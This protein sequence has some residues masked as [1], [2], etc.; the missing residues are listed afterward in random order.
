MKRTSIVLTLA[1]AAVLFT[2]AAAAQ[3]VETIPFRAILSSNNEVPAISGLNATGAATILLHVVRDATGKVVSGSVDFSNVSY[4][5]PAAVTIVASHIHKGTAADNGPVVIPAFSGSLAG[6]TVGVMDQTQAQMSATNLDSVNGILADPSQYYFNVHTTDNPGGAMRGQLQRA[7]AVVL[8]GQ[9]SPANEV[10]TLNPEGTGPAG[11]GLV[12]A[13]R[14]LDANGNTTSGYVVFDVNYTGF[15]SDTVFVGLHIHTGAAG[16]NGPVT[17]NSGLSGQVPGQVA[18]TLHYE[19]EMDISKQATLDALNGLFSNPA[20]YY[21]NAHTAVNGG[22]AIRAQMR[23]TDR[24]VFQLT[25]SPDQE[26]PAITGTMNSANVAVTAYTLRNPDSTV[27]AGAVS[28][29]VNPR[30]SDDTTFNIMHIHDGNAGTNGGVTIDSGL[31]AQ[32]SPV[33]FTGGSGNMMRWVNVA[34][35]AGLATLNSMVQT[36]EKQYFN[37][38]TAASPGGAVRAQLGTAITAVPAVTAVIGSAG[39][40]KSTT[41]APGE[42]VSL[43]GLNFTKVTG[44]LSGFQISNQLPTA[45]NGTQV[46]FNGVKAPFLFVSPGQIN[47]QVPLET[48]NGSQ[49]VVVTSTVG[50]SAAYKVTVADAA[51]TLFFDSVGGLLLKNNDYSLIRPS[52]PATAGD[53]LIIYGTGLGQTTP[54]LLTG[55]LA[56]ANPFQNTV[57]VT[58]T[59][60]GQPATVYYSIAA[61]GFAGLY[62]TAIQVPSG[63]TGSSVPVVLSVGKAAS[64][65]VTIAVK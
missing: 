22:G 39:D 37:L 7:Q 49:N 57:P 11:S 9:M 3:T 20:G 59:V 12:I 18:G 46:T 44:D 51:P 60:G 13:L 23:S 42:L 48:P 64:N 31:N 26:V 65:A 50:P 15:A 55:G 35:T 47:V 40:P 32:R 62:Q 63:V 41:V 29:D 30:F 10:G 28:F 54:A 19:A 8:M 2:T 34:N 36:P 38:H 52:N 17:L 4:R 21:I 6:V 14:S 45:L 43:Y 5:F 27:A 53:V 61:P 24:T 1:S 56:T 16:T 58:V 25:A 33:I